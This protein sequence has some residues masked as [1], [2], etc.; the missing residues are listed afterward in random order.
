[1]SLTMSEQLLRQRAEGALARLRKAKESA[2]AVAIAQA[3]LACERVQVEL[4]RVN[5][6]LGSLTEMRS[7][8][9]RSMTD[10]TVR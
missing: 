8:L 10:V 2:D 7:A 6:A 1:M 5:S 3:R 9:A 4:Q